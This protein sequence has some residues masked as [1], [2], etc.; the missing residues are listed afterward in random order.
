M[1]K[2]SGSGGGEDDR[3]YLR[4]TVSVLECF[5]QVT[6]HPAVERVAHVRSVEHQPKY[7]LGQLPLEVVIWWPWN[8]PIRSTSGGQAHDR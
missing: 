2:L 1:Q 7:T 8:A 5:N 4:I 3:A 6:L